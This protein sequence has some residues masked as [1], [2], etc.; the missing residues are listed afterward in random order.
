MIVAVSASYGPATVQP[1][2]VPL[3]KSYPPGPPPGSAGASPPQAD[4]ADQAPLT[5]VRV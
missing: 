5:Q 2:V 3:S 1:C 4:Q